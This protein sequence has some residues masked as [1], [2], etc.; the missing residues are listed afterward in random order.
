MKFKGESLKNEGF[1][2][3]KVVI[4]WQPKLPPPKFREVDPT[5]RPSLLYFNLV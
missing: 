5:E 4:C 3:Q 1:Q 2:L